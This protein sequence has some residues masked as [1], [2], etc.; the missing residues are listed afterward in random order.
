[1]ENYKI[2]WTDKA[3]AQNLENI[4]FLFQEWSLSSVLNYEKALIEKLEQLEKFPFS[5]P[6]FKINCRKILI[7]KQISLIYKV[8]QKNKEITILI[9]WNNYKNP[10]R[11]LAD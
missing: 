3:I 5:A 9:I 8:S 2:V 10:I 6:V 1:M 4:D 7:V 11:F